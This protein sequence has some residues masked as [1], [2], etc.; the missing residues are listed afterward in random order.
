MTF[1]EKRS[2][3]RMKINV[4][5]FIQGT[6]TEGKSF[7]DLTHTYNV[8][9]RGASLSCNHPVKVNDRLIVSIPAP[10]DFKSESSQ[11]VDSQFN[12]RI[13]RVENDSPQSPEKRI[14]VQFDRPLY[15]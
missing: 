7:Y 3:Y 2:H 5:V 12:A 1:R 13:T 10:M 15:E 14:C 6:D 8:S 9:A 11:E 4:P